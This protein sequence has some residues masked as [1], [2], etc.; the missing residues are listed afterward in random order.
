MAQRRLRGA[1]QSPISLTSMPMAQSCF[2]TA[3]SATRGV[4]HTNTPTSSMSGKDIAP[5]EPAT[6]NR[7]RLRRQNDLGI[8]FI[9]P[10]VNANRAAIVDVARNLLTRCEQDEPAI[11]ARERVRH[12][13]GCGTVIHVEQHR[14]R[15]HAAAMRARLPVART[16]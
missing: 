12:S 1:M 10:A 9:E 6:A 11:V 5:G 16:D 2:A 4:D 13:I 7:N 3:S 8:R 15:I 14:R